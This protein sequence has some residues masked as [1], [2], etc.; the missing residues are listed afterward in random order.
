MIEYY[1]Q[2]LGIGIL[3]GII[4]SWNKK[5]SFA[6]WV[7]AIIV[8]IRYSF[9]PEGLEET[10]SLGWHWIGLTPTMIIGMFI[11]HIAYKDVFSKEVRGW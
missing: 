6:I 8:V 2:F 3:L 10:I 9:S 11:G 4:E 7:L 5:V 1:F